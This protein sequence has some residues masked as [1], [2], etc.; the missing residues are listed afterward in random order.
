MDRCEQHIREALGLAQ[1][2]Q[3]LAE[4]GVADSS[5]DGCMMLYGVVRDCAFQITA[6][7]N[8][9]RERHLARGDSARVYRHRPASHATP[10]PTER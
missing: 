3:T 1:R 4:E 7:A 2:L 10:D 6:E 9:E 8:R 5:D